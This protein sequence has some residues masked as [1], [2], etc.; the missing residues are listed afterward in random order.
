[1]YLITSFVFLLTIHGTKLSNFIEN[2]IKIFASNANHIFIGLSDT[3]NAIIA[4]SKYDNLTNFI[5][6]AWITPNKTYFRIQFGD[7]PICSANARIVKCSVSTDWQLDKKP[8]GY[9]ISDGRK[10]LTLKDNEIIEMESCTG[11][12]DQLF[13]FRLSSDEKPCDKKEKKDKDIIV[14]N[15]SGSNNCGSLTDHQCL[16]SL[17]NIKFCGCNKERFPNVTKELESKIIYDLEPIRVQ[18][19]HINIHEPLSYE[20]KE[21]FPS[22]AKEFENRIVYNPEPILGHEQHIINNQL[23]HESYKMQPINAY[24]EQPTTPMD[25]ETIEVKP[26]ETEP[27]NVRIIKRDNAVEIVDKKTMYNDLANA[28]DNNRSKISYSGSRRNKISVDDQL[29]RVAKKKYKSKESDALADLLEYESSSINNSD[30]SFDYEY[31]AE[32]SEPEN[33]KPKKGWIRRLKDNL[34]KKFRDRKQNSEE[35]YELRRIQKETEENSD[36][37]SLDK[38]MLIKNDSKK[39]ITNKKKPVN[40]KSKNKKEKS[41]AKKPANNKGKGKPLNKKK[42]V[43][44]KGK[45]K[46][47]NIKKPANNKGKQNLKIKNKKPVN[48]KEKVNSK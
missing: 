20:I 6:D 10:C 21:Q 32:P 1:M 48:I 41:V 23:P 37:E 8:L 40:N 24:V 39:P 3:R 7:S 4:K 45:A 33:Q 38:N 35:E 16:D 19:Q 42:P 13:D 25:L 44:N 12:N 5:S 46:P 27:E 43:N 9:T 17:D 36:N 2:D 31:I 15:L 22:I 14:I 47:Q 30:E 11:S 18:E 29:Q 34:K 28:K 26:L